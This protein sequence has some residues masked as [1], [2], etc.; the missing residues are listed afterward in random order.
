MQYRLSIALVLGCLLGLT[1]CAASEAS[2][3]PF[4]PTITPASSATPVSEPT[5]VPT[6][7]PSA[8]SRYGDEIQAAQSA[9]A[10]GA[11][12][13]ALD[14]L[15]PIYAE[16]RDS[17]EI[18]ALLADLYASLGR[19]L[20]A[21]A[22][23]E[24]SAVRDGLDAYVRASAIAPEDTDIGRRVATEREVTQ[25][26]LNTWAALDELLRLGESDVS[27]VERE[28]VA[29]RALA[30]SALA[31]DTLSDFPGVREARTAAL[32]EAGRLQQAL[33][34]AQQSR[35]DRERALAQASEWCG[36]A[37]DLWPTEAAE[38][39][40]A[41]TCLAETRRLAAPPPTT[42]PATAAATGSNTPRSRTFQAI[43][44]RTYQ[45]GTQTAERRS[46]ITGTVVRANGSP[47]AGAVGNV[48][49]A[50]AFV[51]WTTNGAGQF[52]VCG[53]GWS[54]WAVVLDYIPDQPGLSQQSFIGGVWL[55]G[56]AQQQAI[57]VFRER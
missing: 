50:S 35:A 11:F 10:Q 40:A 56:T 25:A 32:V 30:E 51:N 14:I 19:S 8:I 57:I 9:A 34:Q 45:P 4:I 41:R 52:S 1:G 22:P 5:T 31:V 33:A 44:Q 28:P 29:Q 55:D 42:R 26:L 21:E 7:T 48:N 18:A 15:G 43:P 38:G 16:N 20:I 54:N 2:P 24:A 49:N 23:G 53:L 3:P 47:V 13:Q 6:S 27:A 46:C 37:A 12:E 39:A 36:L 17:P